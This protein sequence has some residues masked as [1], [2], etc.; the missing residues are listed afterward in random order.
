MNKPIILISLITIMLMI[1]ACGGSAPQGQALAGNANQPDSSA[2]GKSSDSTQYLDNS[3]T[4]AIP[5]VSQLIIG[6]LKLKGTANEIDAAT[7]KE[8]IPLWKAAKSLGKSDTTSPLEMNGLYRQIQRTMTPEQLAA[9]TE[10]KLSRDNMMQ[11]SQELGISFGGGAGMGN[12]TAEQQSTM[13]ASRSSSGG[14]AAAGGGMMSGGPGGGMPGGMMGG[15]PPEQSSSSNGTT[16]A[17]APQVSQV[18]TKLVDAL[19]K[20]LESRAQQ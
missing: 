8:L 20:Y 12:M 14:G 10:M 5:V 2:G 3:Y 4:N 6:T 17:S 9:I 15:G 16:V 19:I 18:D 7:A 11:I 13:Q 1:T